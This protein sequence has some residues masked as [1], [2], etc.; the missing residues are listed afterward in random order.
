M[1][2][3]AYAQAFNFVIIVVALAMVIILGGYLMRGLNNS[4][5]DTTN[6]E[7]VNQ[8][9]TNIDSMLNE[10]SGSTDIILLR[11]PRAL[12]KMCFIDYSVNLLIPTELRISEIAQEIYNSRETRENPENLFLL[13]ENDFEMHYIGEIKVEPINGGEFGVY[14]IDTKN[15]INLEL[16][17]KGKKV[18][19]REQV[20]N[21]QEPDE[22]PAAGV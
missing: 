15:K 3:K 19:V 14:C 10:N 9:K 1:D 11:P 7:M 17:S 13:T 20:L 12:T 8:I 5:E 22:E 2:K 4:I 16:I 21:Q 6:F 18:L